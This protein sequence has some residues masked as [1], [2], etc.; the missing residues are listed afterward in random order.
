M[1]M[2]LWPVPLHLAR[3]TVVDY[4][5]QISSRLYLVRRHRMI[6]KFRFSTYVLNFDA[7]LTGTDRYGKI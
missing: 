5:H 1:V 2:Y 3:D 6:L 4:F 7:I